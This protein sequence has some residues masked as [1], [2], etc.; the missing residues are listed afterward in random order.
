M[1][2]LLFQRFRF[3]KP[4]EIEDFDNGDEVVAL[5]DK[6][7]IKM[8]KES[9]KRD[10]A[11]ILSHAKLGESDPLLA[12]FYF[13]EDLTPK[14]ERYASMFFRLCQPL[15]DA[16]TY[17]IMRK[18][19]PDVYKSEVAKLFAMWQSVHSGILKDPSN[20]M[21]RQYLSMFTILSENPVNDIKIIINTD[22][23]N[24]A[25]WEGY[26]TALKQ[27]IHKEPNANLYLKL[28][29]ASNAPYKIKII[30]EDNG[31]RYFKIT[32]F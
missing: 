20:E 2:T 19:A 31:F 22:E 8:D 18:Y 21:R 23:E 30:T 32:T 17:K 1:N 27:L 12:T 6:I 14:E 5:Q 25:D 15:Q 28:P 29:I 13:Q 11:E 3:T 16:W 9:E 10:L 24:R 7:V 26:I 4:I